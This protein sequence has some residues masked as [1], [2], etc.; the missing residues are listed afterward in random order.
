VGGFLQAYELVTHDDSVAQLLV[1]VFWNFVVFLVG[2]L[3]IFVW[4]LVKPSKN[5][6]AP[7]TLICSKCSKE[8]KD[9]WQ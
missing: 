5:N 9:S 4:V 2:V 8:N 6:N 7:T 1:S 3:P